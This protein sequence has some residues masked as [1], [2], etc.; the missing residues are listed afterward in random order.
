M[1]ATEFATWMKRHTAAHGISFPADLEIVSSW[2][3]DF[4][5]HAITPAE[6]QNATAAMLGAGRRIKLQEQL[7]WLLD[8][9]SRARDR[10][11]RTYRAYQTGARCIDC[12]DRGRVD[13]GDYCGC[14]AGNARRLLHDAMRRA[15]QNPDAV[16]AK[17]NQSV[18]HG[19]GSK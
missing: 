5:R 17:R 19:A 12:L 7:G 13:N 18:R 3:V 9:V 16:A 15:G 4:Q 8:H 6:A 11:R 10:V 14:D 2:L 1:K